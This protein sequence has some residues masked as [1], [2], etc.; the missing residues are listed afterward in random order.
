MRMLEY[1]D[2]FLRNLLSLKYYYGRDLNIILEPKEKKGGVCGKDP[3]QY[4]VESLIQACDLLDFKP[5]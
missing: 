1:T 4:Y 3:F 2:K 5:N